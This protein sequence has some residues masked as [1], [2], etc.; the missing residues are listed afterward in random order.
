MSRKKL[1][2]RYVDSRSPKFWSDL[3]KLRGIGKKP[4]SNVNGVSDSKGIAHL[5][6]DYYSEIYKSVSFEDE[7]M[8]SLYDTV[9]K[10]V[11]CTSAD[12]RHDIDYSSVK[13]SISKL[14]SGKNDG[15]EG[16]SL[17][18]I[19]NGTELLC[20]HLSNLFSLLL[21]HCCAPTSFCMS[22]MISVPKGSGSIGD[23]KNYRGIALS[24]LLAKL[25]DTCIISSQFD[26]LLS[27]D[28]QFAYKS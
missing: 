14:K 21:S 3:A 1:T 11:N 19:L 13:Y 12:H 9:C 7:E 27:N 8:Q 22:T 23:M 4:S 15:F 18:Y 2:A 5:F 17:D 6:T 16:L 10:R 26:S 28:L 20:H 24:S 25:F